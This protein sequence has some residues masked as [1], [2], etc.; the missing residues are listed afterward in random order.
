MCKRKG[1]LL[2]HLH[3]FWLKWLW[4][5]KY[6]QSGNSTTVNHPLFDSTLFRLFY[7][8]QLYLWSK[9]ILTLE[10]LFLVN[11]TCKFHIDQAIN[12]FKEYYQFFWHF[13]DT[14]YDKTLFQPVAVYSLIWEQKVITDRCKEKDNCS[15]W[16]GWMHLVDCI[17]LCRRNLLF[18]THYF[19][20]MVVFWC[21][22]SCKES[23]CWFLLVKSSSRIVEYGIWNLLNKI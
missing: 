22:Y 8:L 4:L 19:Y 7:L 10:V 14:P 2:T 15:K 23:D 21:F 12:C 11:I 16:E 18:N 17:G 13:K 5:C 20:F 1:K 6:N 3:R 9:C